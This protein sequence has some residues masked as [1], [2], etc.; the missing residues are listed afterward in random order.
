MGWTSRGHVRRRGNGEGRMEREKGGGKGKERSS[1]MS[2]SWLVPGG[3]R[4]KLLLGNCW[5]EPSGIANT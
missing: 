2:G 3:W 4:H 1:F 5:A